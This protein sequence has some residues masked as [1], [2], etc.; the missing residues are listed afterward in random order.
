MA[1][2]NL[3]KTHLRRYYVNEPFL[4][5]PTKTSILQTGH[6]KVLFY[7]SVSY[8]T[9]SNRKYIDFSTSPGTQ[10]SY[11]LHWN[12]SRRT[13]V[14]RRKE[15]LETR[16]RDRRK[17]SIY[18]TYQSPCL[19]PPKRSPFLTSFPQPLFSFL[20]LKP[21]YFIFRQTN[22]LRANVLF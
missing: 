18:R 15:S 12:F 4:N 19:P 1:S 16:V 22:P 13:K 2:R 10:P 17:S 8:T 3:E 9:K 6:T 14:N 11:S 21:P 5:R 7:S 20:R